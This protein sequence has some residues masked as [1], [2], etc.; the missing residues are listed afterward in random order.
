MSVRQMKIENK[1]LQRGLG[2]LPKVVKAS[3]TPPVVKRRRLLGS[4]WQSAGVVTDK[5]HSYRAAMSRSEV[6]GAR[7]AFTVLTIGLRTLTYCSEGVSELCSAFGVREV[8]RISPQKII[9]HTVLIA[10]RNIERR[11]VFKS[12]RDATLRE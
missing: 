12:P 3:L 4:G 9:L 6:L 7:N 1:A 2:S 10:S 11:V 5:C 8:F